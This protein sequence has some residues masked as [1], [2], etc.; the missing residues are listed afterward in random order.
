MVD[1]LNAG[2]KQSGQKVAYNSLQVSTSS[3]PKPPLPSPF[4][5]PSP[6]NLFIHPPPSKPSLSPPPPSSPPTKRPKRR[7]DSGNASQSDITKYLELRDEL[8]D[9]F[10]LSPF[11]PAELEARLRHLVWS[12]GAAPVASASVPLATAGSGWSQ[13]MAR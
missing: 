8:F 12:S 3:P 6:Q 13:P 4:S 1:T 7:I 9:D 2:K 11:H 10:C 5:S